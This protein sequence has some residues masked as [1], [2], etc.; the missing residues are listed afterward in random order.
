M[1][2]VDKAE[3]EPPGHMEIQMTDFQADTKRKTAD[4][5]ANLSHDI[6]VS[7]IDSERRNF[8]GDRQLNNNEV[9]YTDGHQSHRDT[10]KK[11][12][13]YQSFI[14]KKKPLTTE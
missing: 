5:E 9:K 12:S 2:D 14:D 4:K 13:P 1:K 3:P 6:E 10:Q 7:E 11:T 8:V